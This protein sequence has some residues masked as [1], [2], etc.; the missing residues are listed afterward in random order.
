MYAS[1]NDLEATV[2]Q[3]IFNLPFIVPFLIGFMIIIHAMRTYVL[4]D[5]MGY[6]VILQFAF[7]PARYG[8]PEFTFFS[9]FAP[10][11]TPFT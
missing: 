8:S 2:K 9:P 1:D 5:E 6:K 10:Y 4:S 7:I 11:W 3:P